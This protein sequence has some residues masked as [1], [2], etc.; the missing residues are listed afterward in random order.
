MCFICSC[1]LVSY[2][3]VA[4][5]PELLLMCRTRQKYFR[6]ISHLVFCIL[7]LLVSIWYAK[8]QVFNL[9]VLQWCGAGLQAGS[10]PLYACIRP[11][12]RVRPQ[13]LG[14]DPVPPFMALCHICPT[15]CVRFR[16]W[17]P[18][19]P[20]PSTAC[21]DWALHHPHPASGLSPVYFMPPPFSLC[22]RIRLCAALNTWSSAQ[23]HAIHLLGLP[24][25]PVTW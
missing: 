12:I 16:P 8:A 23:G 24:T 9:L 14:S 7:F 17:C 3:A 6:C 21:W 4:R 10:G 5:K 18:V 11:H 20:L 25:G 15:S 19:P 2:K 13:A 1:S 22:A